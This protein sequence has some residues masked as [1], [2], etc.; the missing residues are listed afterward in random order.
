METTILGLGFMDKGLGWFRGRGL[1]LS[2]WG[3]EGIYWGCIGIM[4][5]KNGIYYIIIGYMLGVE[6]GMK[7]FIIWGS[8]SLILD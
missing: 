2:V 8:Y 6:S 5:R 3:N 4:E 7:E 1:G